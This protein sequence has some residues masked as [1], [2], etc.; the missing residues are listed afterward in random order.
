MNIIDKGT[1]SSVLR[2]NQIT[3]IAHNKAIN[4]LNK[5][6]ND[7]LQKKDEYKEIKGPNHL[8]II[9]SSGVIYKNSENKKTGDD[10]YKNKKEKMSYKEYILLRKKYMETENNNGYYSTLIVSQI[11]EDKKSIESI[12][13]EEKKNIR[14]KSK[15]DKIKNYND[16][17]LTNH[18]KELKETKKLYDIN[19]DENGNEV[20]NENL[21]K[22][23][24]NEYKP[25]RKTFTGNFYQ[26]KGSQQKDKK[27]ETFYNFN[28][29]FNNNAYKSYYDGFKKDKKK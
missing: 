5:T 26:R 6:S 4:D 20:I 12:K 1:I 24:K 16:N 3:P 28:N 29:K 11:K 18:K 2:N 15:G 22:Y 13:K 8:K 21:F 10:I 27:L 17:I 23:R 14:S 9:P 7:L 19:F 25:M